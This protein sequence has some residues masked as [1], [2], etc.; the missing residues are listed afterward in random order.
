MASSRAMTTTNTSSLIFDQA[1]GSLGA[2]IT[3]DQYFGTD[4]EGSFDGS[5]EIEGRDDGT[6]QI[7]TINGE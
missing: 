1:I 5:E 2:R 7:P 6:I 3:P 4:E